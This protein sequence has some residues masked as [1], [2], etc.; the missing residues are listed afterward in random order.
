MI[1]TPEAVGEAA[2]ARF[3]QRL[4]ERAWKLEG[5]VR[6]HFTALSSGE[7]GFLMSAG[8]VPV[9]F[10]DQA[11]THKGVIPVSVG[12]GPGASAT[13]PLNNGPQPKGN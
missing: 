12:G 13:R 2:P 4:H 10:R 3:A 8:P 5:A 11:G 7:R 9:K 6:R 1:W